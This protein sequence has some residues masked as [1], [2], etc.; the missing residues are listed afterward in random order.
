M[1][2]SITSQVSNAQICMRDEYISSVF[3]FIVTIIHIAVPTHT[4]LFNMDHSV[5]RQ[6]MI[7]AF[8]TDDQLSI[9]LGRGTSELFQVFQ[10][11]QIFRMWHFSSIVGRFLQN[12]I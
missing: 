7:C 2:K 4:G 10:L 1:H 5:S 12:I 11:K 8:Y 9:S 3:C 6:N